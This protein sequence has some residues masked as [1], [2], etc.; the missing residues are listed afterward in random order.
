VPQLKK[1]EILNGV[2]Y[3]PSRGG[4]RLPME[5]PLPPAA[6]YAVISRAE[7]RP[8]CGVWPIAL[9]DRLP[10]V[11]VPLLDDAGPVQL[12]LQAAFDAVYDAAA[13]GDMLDYRQGTEP[14]L[15]PGDVAWAEEL[16]RRNSGRHG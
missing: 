2:V 13:H 8:V 9:R 6:F 10:P 1:A 5:Q 16:L 3:V 14:P 11:P 15:A 12:D 4:E 7:Q